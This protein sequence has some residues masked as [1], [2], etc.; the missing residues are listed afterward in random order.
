ME[1]A[2]SGV[3]TVVNHHLQFPTVR[4]IEQTTSTYLHIAAEVDTRLPF[5]PGSRTKKQLIARCK[6][7]CAQLAREPGVIDAS[8]FTAILIP[9]IPEDFLAKR[10][11]SVHVA[12]FDVSVLIECKNTEVLDAI[13]RLPAYSEMERTIRAAASYVHVISATNPRHIG[14]VDH[15]RQG[16]FLFNYFFAEAGT[17][18][19]TGC[20]R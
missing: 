14:P 18:C 19:S 10:R 20:L 4:L 11:D 16:V 2:M 17:S 7:W 8:V 9:P 13:C 5:L 15:A 3:L 1:L 6:G 12:R